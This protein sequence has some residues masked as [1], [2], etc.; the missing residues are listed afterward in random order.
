MTKEVKFTTTAHEAKTI[1]KIVD[2]AKKLG[3]MRRGDDRLSIMMDLSAT[4]A[5]GCP[6]DFD[7]MLAADD[8]NFMHDYCGISRHIDRS[9]GELTGFFR[10]RFASKTLVAA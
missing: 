6:M 8:L 10:P 1:G 5:N 2:R 7:R 9:T 4:H 3:L